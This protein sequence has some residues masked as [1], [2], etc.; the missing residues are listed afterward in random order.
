MN[1]S[2]LLAKHQLPQYMLWKG[3]VVFHCFIYVQDLN[4]ISV[5]LYVKYS[6]FLGTSERNK[7]LGYKNSISEGGKR[8]IAH[9]LYKTLKTTPVVSNICLF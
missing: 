7:L 1:I 5:V 6:R 4:F 2:P 3:D 8:T 9:E